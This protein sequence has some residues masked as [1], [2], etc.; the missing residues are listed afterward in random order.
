MVF[1]Q[2]VLR[3]FLASWVC[4]TTLKWANSSV[5]GG[6]PVKT[7][8]PFRLV[9]TE[10]MCS[11]WHQKL[12]VRLFN[13]YKCFT[14]FSNWFFSAAVMVPW[15]QKLKWGLLASS[16]CAQNGPGGF[17]EVSA[18]SALRAQLSLLGKTSP[19]RSR[20]SGERSRYMARC[21]CA[22]CALQDAQ[23]PLT[24]QHTRHLC[25]LRPHPMLSLCRGQ[26]ES[27]LCSNGAQ[28]TFCLA[29]FLGN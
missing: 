9:C 18:L 1:S 26:P 27:Q 24:L 2:L 8:K 17:G 29:L 13:F 11:K 22:L 5:W 15:W 3:W 23:Q 7:R 21:C 6:R 28:L 4:K 25:S 20:W 10:A 12:A 14:Q 19:S 16:W